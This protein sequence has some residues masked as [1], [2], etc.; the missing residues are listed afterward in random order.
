M[1]THSHTHSHGAVIS[2]SELKVVSLVPFSCPTSGVIHL[3][4]GF[5]APQHLL[6][7]WRGLKEGHRMKGPR[8]LIYEPNYTY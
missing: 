5:S 6:T 3:A 2:S 1:Y 4:R 8:R 7:G